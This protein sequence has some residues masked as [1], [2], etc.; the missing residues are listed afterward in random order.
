MRIEAAEVKTE[1]VGPWW[2]SRGAMVVWWVL[3]GVALGFA[4]GIPPVQRTQEARVLETAR[5]MLG[6]G[7]G[8]YRVP[9]LTGQS[10]VRKP[11]LAYWLAAGAYKIGG[12]SEGVGR[13][14]TVI[15]GWLTLLVT[16][17]GAHWLF[18]RRAGFFACGALLTSY[19]FFRHSRLAETD[20]PAM[21][22]VTVG[23]LAFWKGALEED[24]ETRRQGDRE[25]LGW[26]G[27]WWFHLGAM[28]TALAAMSKGPPGFYPPLFLVF[29]C[30]VR[31]N[32]KPL[33]RL[34]RSGAVLTLA[35]IA[36][37]WFIYVLKVVGLEQWRKE[38]DE[39][40]G[41][42]AH[43]GF[44]LVYVPHLIQATAPWC[45]V[46]GGSLVAACQ[47]V[48]RF[49]HG[50]PWVRWDR[51]TDR[52][53]QGMLLWVVAVF[54]PLCFVGN[55][56]VHYLTTLIPPLMILAGWWLDLVLAQG[57]RE[58]SSPRVPLLD[59]TMLAAMLAVPAIFVAAKT[60]KGHLG[61][62]DVAVAVLLS[63]ALMIVGLVYWRR[64]LTSA[65]IAFMIG[66]AVV[67]VP[68]VGVWVP[69]AE[70][71]NSRMV[72]RRLTR[73]F[74][75]GPYCFYGSS[76]SLP[77]CFNLRTEIPLAGNPEELED[78]AARMPGVVVI[79][80][81]KGEKAPP[82]VPAEFVQLP[83]DIEVPKQTYRIFKHR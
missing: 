76:F 83:P 55:K 18:G 33:V 50:R 45:F 68:A 44:F 5:E 78:L 49:S 26:K 74:G 34:L 1:V 41:G 46:V 57:S 30:L 16:F 3:A 79:V 54:A 21:L 15:M 48:V 69:L 14:P 28:G 6:K 39:L 66:A 56:Q 2:L 75:S 42:D 82:P 67:F 27:F 19:L 29:W 73:R 62:Y 47:R 23:V 81:S 59:L 8:G 31:G 52:R 80:Q 64:G 53:L 35:V 32:W 20:T 25:T 17:L 70:P 40:L 4:V 22:F 60:T 58:E 38:S 72:A 77:L 61:F 9:V 11:P 13:T 37:P 36:A 12:V 43:G 71:G 65:T 51:E 10:R 63:V 7:F 24:K